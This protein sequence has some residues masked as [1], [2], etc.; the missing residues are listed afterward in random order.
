MNHSIY[1]LFVNCAQNVINEGSGGEKVTD[2]KSVIY[3]H[4]DKPRWMET[5]K[6]S[7]I[8]SLKKNTVIFMTIIFQTR[9]DFNVYIIG[10]HSDKVFI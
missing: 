2:Y 1:F 5:I 3:Y 10:I 4:E 7:W 9:Q 6:V 8:I